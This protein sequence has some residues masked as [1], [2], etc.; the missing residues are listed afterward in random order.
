LSGITSHCRGT[1]VT[2]WTTLETAFIDKYQP[3]YDTGNHNSSFSS[4]IADKVI[5]LFNLIATLFFATMLYEKGAYSTGGSQYDVEIANFTDDD[6]VRREAKPVSHW[7]S[8]A[9][10][11]T[12]DV[13]RRVATLSCWVAWMPAHPMAFWR[14]G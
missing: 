14:E 12:H 10:S 3:S 2:F 7:L 13:T 5:L 9:D 11:I 8:F 1:R 6:P 4:L